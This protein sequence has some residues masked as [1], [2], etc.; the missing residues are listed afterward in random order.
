MLLAE[1]LEI[2]IDILMQ[3]RGCQRNPCSTNGFCKAATAKVVDLK[4][5]NKARTRHALV[6]NLLSRFN[7]QDFHIG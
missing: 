4:V 6:P 3:Q 5:P 7:C 2:Q 1:W